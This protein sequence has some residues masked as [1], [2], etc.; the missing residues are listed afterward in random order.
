M[1]LL[2]NPLF[3]NLAVVIEYNLQLVFVVNLL[4]VILPRILSKLIF[5]FKMLQNST[6]SKR[7]FNQPISEIF[8]P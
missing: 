7:K 1:N 5:I 2:L 6:I 3:F 4:L 8:P